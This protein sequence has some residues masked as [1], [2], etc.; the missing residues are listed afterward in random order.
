[1]TRLLTSKYVYLALRLII[2]LL[3]VYAGALKLSNPEGFAVTINIYGLTTWRMS[4]VL[5]YVIPTVEILAGLGLALDVKGGLALVVAQLLGFMAVLLYALHLGLDADCGCF[6]T[7]KNTDN[8][9]TGPLV[10][11][12]RDAAMLAG[13]ALIHLQ[14]RYVGFRPRSLTRLF[15]STD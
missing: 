8:A 11:F 5:S 3:F 6:G 12:L 4:G 1:M 10:A 2:G 9:P 14:R 7:P 15:R 13:C